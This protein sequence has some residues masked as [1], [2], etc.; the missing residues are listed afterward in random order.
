MKMLSSY[1]GKFLQTDNKVVEEDVLNE[2][3]RDSK[4]VEWLIRELDVAKMIVEPE[5]P[6]H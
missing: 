6:C 1:S 2:C 5:K 4:G 3:W